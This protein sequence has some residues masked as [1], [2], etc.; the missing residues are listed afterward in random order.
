MKYDGPA[1]CSSGPW[2]VEA[3]WLN[4]QFNEVK[5]ASDLIYLAHE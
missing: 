3:V 5:T 4:D 1:L 2:I